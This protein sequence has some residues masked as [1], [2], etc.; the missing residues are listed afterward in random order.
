MK[1]LL[2]LIIAGF[3]A[4]K[5]DIDCYN[6]LPVVQGIGNLGLTFFILDPE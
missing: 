5:A 3:I 1:Q 2:L 6:K 4:I